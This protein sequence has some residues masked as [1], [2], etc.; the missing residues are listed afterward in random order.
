MKPNGLA[1]D[2]ARGILIAANIGDPS[3][4]D[5]YS[6]SVVDVARRERIAEVKVPGRTLGDLRRGARDVL[7]QRRRAGVDHRDRCA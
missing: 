1:F 7:R 3:I 6:V 4:A 2:P 5:S